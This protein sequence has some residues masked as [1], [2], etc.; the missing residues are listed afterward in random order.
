[1][2]PEPAPAAGMV[3]YG[4]IKSPTAMDNLK[5]L[6]SRLRDKINDAIDTLQLDPRPPEHKPLGGFGPPILSLKVDS[7]YSLQY[8]VDDGTQRVFIILVTRFS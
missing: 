6:P 5:K 7:E 2:G 1:M 8:Q 3:F 4:I